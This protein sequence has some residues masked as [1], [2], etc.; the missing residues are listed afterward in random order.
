MSWT[1][2]NSFPIVW[3][4]TLMT[5]M[6]LFVKYANLIIFPLL[7]ESVIFNPK[8]PIVSYSN[9]ISPANSVKKDLCCSV[10][11]VRR[12]IWKI[13][14]NIYRVKIWHLSNAK[15]AI[16]SI[17]GMEQLVFWVR[18][19]IVSFWYH[20]PNVN[21]VFLTTAELSLRTI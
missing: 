3:I 4:T 8:D 12:K 10:E 17:I 1:K 18:L 16:K 21:S 20:P 11:S 15:P 13:V 2:P 5:K 6:N 14:R 9:P 19:K 7:M